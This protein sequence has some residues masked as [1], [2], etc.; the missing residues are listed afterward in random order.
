MKNISHAHR[1]NQ[2]WASLGGVK[3]GPENLCVQRCKCAQAKALQ[4]CMRILTVCF[5]ARCLGL[6]VVG[7]SFLH[8]AT[9]SR[10]A[11][12][13]DGDGADADDVDGDEAARGKRAKHVWPEIDS[14]NLPGHRSKR[15]PSS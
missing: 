13:G 8:V 15:L 11:D 4:V 3:N 9:F 7:G 2:Q 6:E 12:G 1:A 14:N 10:L 5:D